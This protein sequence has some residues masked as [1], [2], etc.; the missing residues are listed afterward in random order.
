MNKLPKKPQP[1]PIC[2]CGKDIIN[3]GSDFCANCG[4]LLSGKTM[5][6]KPTSDKEL[7]KYQKEVCI[8]CKNEIDLKR[9]IFTKGCTPVDLHGMTNHN[10][11]IKNDGTCIFYEDKKS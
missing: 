8:N 10:Q 5:A 6:T 7:L 3:D 9:G 11:M 1:I 2:T 4:L